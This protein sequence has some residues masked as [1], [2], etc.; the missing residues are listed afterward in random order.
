VTFLPDV[1]LLMASVWANHEHHEKVRRWLKT[2]GSFAS[3]PL[4]Q[5]GFARISSH[6]ELGFAVEPEDAFRELRGLLK[7]Q[8][9]RFIP[10][11][12]TCEDRVLRT[13]A[14]QTSN[15]VTD[16]YLVALAREH[17]CTLATLDQPLAKRFSKEPGIVHL[18]C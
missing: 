18:V 5:L 3:C 4:A 2:V 9:H 15:E 16:H 14:M 17:N 1:N 6:P 8:R 12:V 7:D 10:D 11:S 13:D